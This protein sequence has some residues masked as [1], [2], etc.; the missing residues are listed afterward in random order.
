MY[1]GFN[2]LTLKFGKL[3]LLKRMGSIFKSVFAF[4][5]GGLFPPS[6]GKIKI[7]GKS[8]AQQT[9]TARK[10]YGRFRRIYKTILL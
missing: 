5:A 1:I 2:F 9:K 7:P 10:D 4:G 6:C 8:V 3:C